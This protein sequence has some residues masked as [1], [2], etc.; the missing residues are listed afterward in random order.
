[1][2]TQHYNNKNYNRRDCRILFLKN[3][4][5]VEEIIQLVDSGLLDNK[6]RA[7][8]NFFIC[9]NDIPLNKKDFNKLKLLKNVVY[10]QRMSYDNLYTSA[11][12]KKIIIDNKIDEK[13]FKNDQFVLFHNGKLTIETIQ[14][15]EKI[16]FQLLNINIEVEKMKEERLQEIKNRI[17]NFIKN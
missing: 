13:Q 12:A 5:P 14:K 4:V 11:T 3:E 7:T 8:E 17:K 1:M 15:E 6:F 2:I 16:S 10:T 9:E